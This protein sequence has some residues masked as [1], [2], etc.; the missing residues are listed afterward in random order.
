MSQESILN[1][2]ELGKSEGFNIYL[3]SMDG[4]IT[5]VARTLDNTFMGYTIGQEVK[6]VNKKQKPASLR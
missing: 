2:I 3:A 1:H 4:Y 6:I 5:Y